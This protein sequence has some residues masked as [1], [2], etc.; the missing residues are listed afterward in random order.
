VPLGPVGKGLATFVGVGAFFYLITSYILVS[1]IV[2]GI[3]L[4]VS[5]VAGIAAW[6]DETVKK[7]QMIKKP[8]IIV[9][10]APDEYPLV[11]YVPPSET[12]NVK[13]LDSTAGDGAAVRS[14]KDRDSGHPS[15]T[16]NEEAIAPIYLE[17]I[18]AVWPLLREKIDGFK[19]THE[20]DYNTITRGA[21]ILI[22]AMAGGVIGI[23][24]PVTPVYPFFVILALAHPVFKE[25]IE[26]LLGQKPERTLGR[27][28]GEVISTPLLMVG[29]HNIHYAHAMLAPVLLPFMTMANL[30]ASYM[31]I[32]LL[33]LLVRMV[34]DRIR[35]GNKKDVTSSDKAGDTVPGTLEEKIEPD[36][37]SAGPAADAAVSADTVKR[38]YPPLQ[39]DGQARRNAMIVIGSAIGLGAIYVFGGK[40]G[41]DYAVDQVTT[42]RITKTG[43]N[44][45]HFDLIAPD[46]DLSEKGT[47]EI[48]VT[49]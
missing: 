39:P 4:L 21:A 24:T 3:M 23:L 43:E 5:A 36:T 22:L 20:D 18:L 37:A 28:V 35:E 15:I 47:L 38:A 46:W 31:L 1:P 2:M 17:R 6:H 13:K 32:M 44:V 29:L 26:V 42:K 19:Q 48:Y 16:T 8:N 40:P 10:S 30:Y 45:E 14:D 12:S 33:G 49:R 27:D 41:R 7:Y 9:R 11:T 34:I 25:K